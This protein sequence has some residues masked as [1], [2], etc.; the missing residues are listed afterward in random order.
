MHAGKVT[1][2]RRL[3]AT[4]RALRGGNWRSTRAIMRATGSVAVHSDLAALRANGRNYEKR[5]V[6]G[7]DG[8]RVYYYRLAK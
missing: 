4:L 3:Q 8:G 5:S 1:T 6:A 2:S 7:N